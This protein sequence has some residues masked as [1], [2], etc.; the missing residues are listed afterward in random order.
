MFGY[1][2]ATSNETKIA[3]SGTFFISYIRDK[4]SLY[5]QEYGVLMVTFVQ[6]ERQQMQQIMS[7]SEMTGVPSSCANCSCI[8]GRRESIPGCG[9]L[10]WK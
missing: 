3:S 4:K 10:I 6:D 1:K 7:L 2:L 5:L 8:L 9:L